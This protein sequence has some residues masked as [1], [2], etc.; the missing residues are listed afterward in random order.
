MSS[1][2]ENIIVPV[3]RVTLYD[4]VSSWAI[5]LFF[6]VLVSCLFV[7]VIWVSTRTTTHSVAVPVELVELPG[8][9]LDGT[10]GETLRVDSPEPESREASPAD[11]MEDR[12]EIAAAVESVV[13]MAD[14]A[15]Q[16]VQQQFETGIQNSGKGGSA[17]GTGRRAL[18]FGNGTGGFP[19]EQRWF[20]RFSEKAALAEYAKQL[21]F[22]GIELGA[23]LPDGRLAYLSKPSADVPTI[24]FVKS[25]ADETRL[26]MTWQGGERRAADVQLFAKAKIDIRSDTILFHFYPKKIEEELAELEIAYRNRKASQIRRTYFAVEND[27]ARY[28]FS[29][30]RQIPYQ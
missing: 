13:Q 14:T 6:A 5:S 30:Y 9:F 4:R 12:V 29:V 16:N 3:M 15:T 10:P 17:K 22:F 24:R 20:V 26:Y 8:G 7:V 19:R 18:G 27:G 1:R 28:K 25:G 2:P 23:L 11:S 21:E